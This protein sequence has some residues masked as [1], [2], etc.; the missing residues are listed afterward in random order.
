VSEQTP[1]LLVESLSIFNAK[2]VKLQNEARVNVVQV[3]VDA[4]LL[5]NVVIEHSFSRNCDHEQRPQKLLEHQL[6]IVS[7]VG[8][9]Y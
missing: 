8:V 5:G 7:R 2:G 9:I 6:R 4:I 3:G 1:L